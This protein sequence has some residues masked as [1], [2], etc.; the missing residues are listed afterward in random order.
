MRRSILRYAPVA[1]LPAFAL[2]ACSPA[3]TGGNDAM[4][5]N[6]ASRAEAMEQDANNRAEAMAGDMMSD[7][8]NQQ[9]AEAALADNG[10]DA[11]DGNASER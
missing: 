5:Q 4:D 2:A 6:M 7:A 1:A 10:S 9:A 8:A 11:A 3:A